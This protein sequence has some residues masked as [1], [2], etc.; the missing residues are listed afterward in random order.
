MEITEREYRELVEKA[1][2]GEILSKAILLTSELNYKKDGL[3]FNDSVINATMKATA[4][5]HWERRMQELLAA[6][7]EE[8]NE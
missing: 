6:Q 4:Y 2:A 3:N 8:T 1:K 5:P 7:T